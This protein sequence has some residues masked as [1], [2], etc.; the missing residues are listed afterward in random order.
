MAGEAGAVDWAQD[1][2]WEWVALAV[3][4]IV[5][6]FANV[7]I[8]RVPRGESVV[9]PRSRCPACGVPIAWYDN[10]PVLSYFVLRGRCRSCR[11]PIS[12]RYPLIEATNGALYVLLMRV[13]GPSLQCAFAMV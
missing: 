9:A 3:G 12:F 2:P 13:H 4:L 8:H 7:C 10:L 1:L 5:G 6:S 11:A